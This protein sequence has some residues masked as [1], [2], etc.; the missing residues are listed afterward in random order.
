MFSGKAQSGK[1]ASANILKSLLEQRGKRVLSV[2]MAD[3]L[4][5]IATQYL[6]WDGKKDEAGRELLQKLGTEKVRSKWPDFWVLNVLDIIQIFEDDFDYILID[7]VRFRNEIVTI[8][9]Y[10][11]GYETISVRVER[12]GFDNG[13]TEEQKAHES[14]TQLDDFKFTI[15]ISAN[16]IFG[17]NEEVFHNVLKPVLWMGGGQ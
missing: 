11:G 13:L 7:D 17:L 14:E 10:G 16:D 15:Y 9:H 3:R 6:G 2:S 5:H 12:P 1:T 4:R 8:E